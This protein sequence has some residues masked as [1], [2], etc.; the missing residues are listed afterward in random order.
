[1]TTPISPVQTTMEVPRNG[2]RMRAPTIS[3]TITAAPQEK[4]VKASMPA[5]FVLRLSAAVYAYR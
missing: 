1:M 4:T 3:S 5:P 2:A